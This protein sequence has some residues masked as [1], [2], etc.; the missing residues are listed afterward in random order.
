MTVKKRQITTYDFDEIFDGY[1]VEVETDLDNKDILN[2]YIYHKQCGIKDYMFG[3]FKKQMK[4]EEITVE[5]IISGNIGQSI[6]L[7]EKMLEK[8]E[9]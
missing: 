6:K 1:C 5:D 3:I 7:Y 9:E 8:L 2:F 4:Q